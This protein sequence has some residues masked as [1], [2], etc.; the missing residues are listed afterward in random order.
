MLHSNNIARIF[1]NNVKITTDFTTTDL[2]GPLRTT[3]WNANRRKYGFLAKI[4]H[5]VENHNNDIT[6]VSQCSIDRL[7]QLAEMALNWDGSITCA[8]LVNGR[9]AKKDIANVANVFDRVV[10]ANKCRLD[11]IIMYPRVPNLEYPIN[12]LRN[13]A[14][15][16]VRYDSSHVFLLDID[17]IPS[18]NLHSMIKQTH[19]NQNELCVIP[20]LTVIDKNTEPPLMLDELIPLYN[21][22]NVKV[23]ASH[24]QAG[25]GAT[26]TQKWLEI[27]QTPNQSKYL[28]ADPRAGYEPYVVVNKNGLPQYDEIFVGYGCNKIQHIYHLI[29]YKYIFYVMTH[30]FVIARPHAETKWCKH[31]RGNWKE[32]QR[33]KA[34]YTKFVN[35]LK[36]EPPRQI[37]QN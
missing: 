19:F 28:I 3:Q 31:F 18:N 11:V 2:F 23:F 34:L 15:H 30:G 6:I 22:Q 27:S 13:V 26:D 29:K 36:Y 1:N 14:L 10:T 25:H 7:D 17:F 35:N 24:Y 20:A 5:I 4:E 16:N 12:M 21:T 8:I 37:I 9:N 32:R 33:I